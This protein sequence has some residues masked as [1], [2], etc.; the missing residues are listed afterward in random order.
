MASRDDGAADVH[1]DR[2]VTLAAL[3]TMAGVGGLILAKHPA[4]HSLG[5]TVFVGVAVALPT[6]LWITPLL[7]ERPATTS[8][9][10]PARGDE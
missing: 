4:L 5:L 6:A 2:A 9:P 10:A 1:T 8:S 7:K 3:N